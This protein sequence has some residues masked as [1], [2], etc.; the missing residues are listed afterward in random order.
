MAVPLNLKFTS[1]GPNLST[2]NTSGNVSF[3]DPSPIINAGPNNRCVTFPAFN[4][5][6][7]VNIN[8]PYVV[9]T[10]NDNSKLFTLYFRYKIN[11]DIMD[12]VTPVLSYKLKPSDGYMIPLLN[13]LEKSY[14]SFHDKQDT[15]YNSP[16]VS[17]TFDGK[18][19]TFTLERRK[20]PNGALYYCY[21]IDGCQ[22]TYPDTRSRDISDVCGS[23]APLYLGYIK[24]E[25]GETHTFNGGSI[26]NIVLVDTNVYNNS[27]VPPT[28]Y[29]TG[30]DVADNYYCHIRAKVDGI[31][32]DVIDEVEK[33]IQHSKYHINEAQKDYLPRRIRIEWWQEINYF[34][35]ETYTTTRKHH[36]PDTILNIRLFEHSMWFHHKRFLKGNA[37][38]LMMN[39]EIQ[40]FVM[41]VDKR[42]VPLTQIDFLKSDDNLNVIIKN[43]NTDHNEWVKSVTIITI[44]FPI[45]Y[46]EGLGERVDLKPLYSF[47]Q[48]GRFSIDNSYTYYYIDNKKN[49]NIAH[50]GI[51]EQD[52]QGLDNPENSTLSPNRV[53]R[54][55]WRYGEFT[56]SNISGNDAILQ[57]NP[58]DGKGAVKPGDE[59]VLYKN[60]TQIHRSRYDIVGDNLVKFYNYRDQDLTRDIVTMQIITD[61]SDSILEDLTD[62]RTVSVVATKDKQSVFEIPEVTDGDGFIYRKFLLFRGS[63]CMENKNRYTIDYDSNTV[64]FNNTEDFVNKGTSILF[65]FVKIKRADQYGVLHV[66][67][68]YL[69]TT[70]KPTNAYNDGY[71]FVEWCERIKIPEYRNLKYNINQVMLFVQGTFIS[72]NRYKIEENT[73]YFTQPNT[74]LKSGKS[75]T[76]VLLQMVNRFED[77]LDD[78][79]KIIHDQLLKGNRFV[80]YDLYIDKKRKITLDNFVT[81]DQNGEYIPDLYG[82]IYNMNIIKE[83]HTGEPLH[84]RVRYLTCVYF[85]DSLD[86]YAN[87]TLPY[88]NEFIKDYISLRQEFYEIDNNFDDFVKDFDIYH[89]S[90][91]SY[92]VNLANA[93]NY[94]VTYNQNLLDRVFENNTS[95]TRRTYKGSDLNANLQY[96]N[97][98]YY[99]DV[100]GDNDFKAHKHYSHPIFFVNGEYA[101]WNKDIIKKGNRN[102]LVLSSRFNSND[103]IEAIYFHHLNNYFLLPL[104]FAVT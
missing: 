23:T 19:H 86:N 73:V 24:N 70:T 9:S 53:M 80:L 100:Y 7:R 25:Y 1:S 63:L 22:R 78:R 96:S 88:N 39:N 72:P 46:E 6:P 52:F 57:F 74:Y 48:E 8:T 99:L 13:I 54:N 79:D 71:N 15:L 20:K 75:V 47:D 97:G 2:V 43:R 82:Y 36:R 29:F 77:P 95:C 17:Y 30:S 89:K 34:Q 49:P 59:I 37:Y 83:L 90:D 91:K 60:T 16:D 27:F 33:A 84:R 28:L 87:I 50:I 5:T 32:Q 61:T 81:F 101:E 12:D 69:Y 10:F 44:P 65:V 18:W 68:V 26:D 56:T 40:P 14:F 85:K 92:G 41:F 103:V 51:Q 102:T 93:L 104:G 4:S 38:N 45:I 58:I 11:K 31:E 21:F 55:L 67:P 98:K 62:V 76:F 3:N 64:T 66:K 94:I 42:F 35:N